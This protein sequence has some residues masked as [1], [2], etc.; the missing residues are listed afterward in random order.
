MLC[1]I[2]TTMEEDCV[3]YAVLDT[4]NM[5]SK[6]ADLSYRL[7]SALLF[8]YLLSPSLYLAGTFA[9]P[10][11]NDSTDRQLLLNMDLPF[12]TNESPTYELVVTAQIVHQTVSVFAFGIFSSLLLMMV[13]E[14]V[15]VLTVIVFNLPGSSVRY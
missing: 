1:D 4:N 8:L 2:I 15:C 6:T 3:K 7:T 11:Y 14:N 5:I 12:D 13:S 10:R 9:F